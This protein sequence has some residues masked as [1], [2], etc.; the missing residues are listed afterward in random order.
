LKL[1]NNGGERV[2]AV[3]S[4]RGRRRLYIVLNKNV[5]IVGRL[6]PESPP[7]VT[8]APESLARD[9]S[10]WPNLG[11]ESEASNQHPQSRPSHGPE[12]LAPEGQSLRLQPVDPESLAGDKSLRPNSGWIFEPFDLVVS[13]GQNSRSKSPSH[14]GRSLRPRYCNRFISWRPTPPLTPSRSTPLNYW[15]LN[16]TLD[17]RL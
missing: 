10:L 9:K 8:T 6:G 17:F 12:S 7:K 15:A 2:E 16:P 13:Q 14:R 3:A 4:S 11:L 5:V 1:C